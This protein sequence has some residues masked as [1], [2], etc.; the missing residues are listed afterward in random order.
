M[1]I[2]IT[3]WILMW[4]WASWIV[5]PW[6]Y[7]EKYKNKGYSGS[8]LLFL[9]VLLSTSTI[10]NHTDCKR[11]QRRQICWSTLMGEYLPESQCAG[12]IIAFLP[13]HYWECSL[14]S[15]VGC[16]HSAGS[17][18]VTGEWGRQEFHLLHIHSCPFQERTGTPTRVQGD[19]MSRGGKGSQLCLA[20]GWLQST[21]IPCL[22]VPQNPPK[23]SQN[24]V[25][26]WME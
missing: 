9:S 20:S 25:F 13:Q 19:A 22:S 12:V 14:M 17:S 5:R 18:H 8:N 4:P 3:Y 15:P 11:Q 16:C 2:S 23:E 26:F 21:N 10:F 6:N 7:R 1:S 24:L